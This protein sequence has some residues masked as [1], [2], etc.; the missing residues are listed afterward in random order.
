MND[1]DR[2]GVVRSLLRQDDVGRIAARR[3]GLNGELRCRLWTV[4]DNDNYMLWHDGAPLFARIYLASKHW[5]TGE[6]DCHFELEFMQHLHAH[7]VAVAH[8]LPNSDG[9]LLT[10][11]VAPEG[12]R[13]LALFSYANGVIDPFP[14]DSARCAAI[15]RA[16]ASVH[17]AG[18]DFVPR[19]ARFAIDTD[20]ML[21]NPLQ[22]I[23]AGLQHA[24]RPALHTVLEA[25]RVEVMRALAGLPVRGDGVVFGDFHGSNYHFSG[26]LVTMFDF[27]LCGFGWHAHDLATWT[28]DARKRHGDDRAR[29]LL[30]ALL[31]GYETVMPLA[32]ASRAA[33]PALMIA[34]E[35]WLAGEHCADIESLGAER[36]NEL[37]WE[38]FE[39][40]L[41]AWLTAL[42]QQTW[43]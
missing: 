17:R 18:T 21:L 23:A 37:Y 13:Y 19:H 22:R 2:A 15:G 27:D 26:D 7:G 14:E 4:G 40:R 6:S 43:Y 5:G 35:I 38:R 1:L 32:A 25:A 30:A 29:A 42:P 33:I 39:A 3:Y 36:L 11:L 41:A 8:P 24:R 34:R 20:F 31:R 16:L 9:Q 28:W 10:P 12:T